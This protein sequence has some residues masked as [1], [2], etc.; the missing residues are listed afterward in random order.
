VPLLAAVPL[1]V[2]G[3]VDDADL[4]GEEDGASERTPPQGSEGAF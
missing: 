2:F 3:L 4:A 1:L